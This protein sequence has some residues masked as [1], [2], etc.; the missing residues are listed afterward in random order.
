MKSE[1]LK[2]SL[3][4]G[5]PFTE[6]SPYIVLGVDSVPAWLSPP[7]DVGERRGILVGTGAEV[8]IER[9]GTFRRELNCR[10]R[11]PELAAG[12]LDAEAGV[13]S[14]SKRDSKEEPEP[15]ES[16]RMDGVMEGTGT[17]CADCLRDRATL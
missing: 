9:P 13:L 14:T 10:S 7:A 12:E 16:A 15:S 8:T 4:D 6:L 11:D 2:S 5:A 17:R 1:D 3:A